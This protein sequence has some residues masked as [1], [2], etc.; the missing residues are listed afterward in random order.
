MD[1]STDPGCSRTMDPDMTI[2]GS[3]SMDPD[4]SMASGAVQATHIH[5]ASR[6]QHG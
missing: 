3:S 4:S 6:G 1:I 2:G 5:M